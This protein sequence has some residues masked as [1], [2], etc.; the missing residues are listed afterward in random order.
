MTITDPTSRDLFKRWPPS[1]PMS[2]SSGGH[3]SED[4]VATSPRKVDVHLG[5]DLGKRR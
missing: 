5:A 2:T 1:G 4:I 3:G